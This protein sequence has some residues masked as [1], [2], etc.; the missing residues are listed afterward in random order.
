MIW[1]PRVTVAAVVEQ[2][3]K[4]LLVEE[5][6]SGQRVLNQP[7]GHLESGEGLQTAV[8]REVWEETA[9]QFK[10]SAVVGIYLWPMLENNRSYLRFCFT[11][12]VS[13]RH[14][15]QELDED[16][17]DTCWLDYESLQAHSHLR[18]PMVLQCV[19]DYR[20]NLRIPLDLLH[21]VA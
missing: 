19:Q 14:P 11:G 6:I 20:K 9:R 12:S 7:A 15:N 1:T 2:N 4:F 18:S 21:D 17:L 5:L 3:D 8:I 10:P 13:E 16:I